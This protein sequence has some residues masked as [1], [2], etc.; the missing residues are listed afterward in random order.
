MS[1]P[2]IKL[3][4]TVEKII[5]P[6]EKN[7]WRLYDRR[8][9]ATADLLALS[10]EDPRSETQVLLHHPTDPSKRRVL[11]R[12]EIASVEP[13]LE[14]V[15]EPGRPVA[16]FPTIPELRAR[17]QADVD[18]LDPGVR[19]FV[20]PHIYHVSLSRN[21]WERKQQLIESARADGPDV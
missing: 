20:N 2:S 5:N 10:Y 19:R 6:G 1:L 3:S 9:L 13:L 21:L 8:G 12:E 17:R 18:R 16:N 11:A 14:S 7:V 4:E 15:L